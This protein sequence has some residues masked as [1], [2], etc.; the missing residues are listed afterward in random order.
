MKKFYDLIE[1]KDIGKHCEKIGYALDTLQCIKI[2]YNSTRISLEER[3]H[4]Y[5]EIMETMPESFLPEDLKTEHD[6]MLYKILKKHIKKEKQAAETFLKEA[7]KPIYQGLYYDEKKSLQEILDYC[8]EIVSPPNNIKIY[9]TKTNEE[10]WFLTD[11]TLSSLDIYSELECIFYECDIPL[12]PHPFKRG[13]IVCFDN[14]LQKNQPCIFDSMHRADE[15]ENSIADETYANE[16][17]CD[18]IHGRIEKGTIPYEELTY[19]TGEFKKKDEILKVLSD[20]FHEKI[21]I[22]TLLNAYVIHL[23]KI[24][25][26]LLSRD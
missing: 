11:G 21:D 22:A 9:N 14:Y 5:E 17:S 13:D 24:E 12:L 19:F 1:S 4:L 26:E 10:A 25:T 20:Y 6:K 3:H 18:Y 8:A 15:D 23:N 2:V 7:A 16:Y